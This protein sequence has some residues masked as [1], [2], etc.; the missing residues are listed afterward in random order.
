[1]PTTALALRTATP[2][3]AVMPAGDAFGAT[4]L[5]LGYGVFMGTYPVPIKAPAVQAAR[6]HPVVFQCYKSFWVMATG[7]LFAIPVYAQ[8]HMLQL[9][10]WAL[11]SA[12]CW[13]PS[14]LSTVAGVNFIGVSLTIVISC[15][16]SS[17]GSFL[18]FWLALGEKIKAHQI[19]GRTV[20]LAPFWLAGCVLGMVALVYGPQLVASRCGARAKLHADGGALLD[21]DGPRLDAEATEQGA[22]S[23]GS[24]PS[25]SRF[26]IGLL[27]ACSSGTFGAVQYAVVTIGRGIEEQKAGCHQKPSTCPEALKQAFD[28]LGS[29][30]FM[31]GLGAGGVAALFL[32]VLSLYRLGA[33]R[34]VRLAAPSPVAPRRPRADFLPSLR[35]QP[36]TPASD[37]RRVC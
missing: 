33:G 8:G 1:M 22:R 3:H 19:G 11:L 16:V 25:A 12:L 20:Y 9:T 37:P 5:A 24:R 23:D 4:A 10:P 7:L 6:V 29:W 31:F 27:L 13:V 18:V 2:H 32:A 21:A 36:Q 17:V 15:A 30:S 26:V 34:E 14:G 35:P 28:P